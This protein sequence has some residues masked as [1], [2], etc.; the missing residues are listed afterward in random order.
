MKTKNVIVLVLFLSISLMACGHEHKWIDATCTSPKTCEE[1]GETEGEPL[2][3][4]T[5]FGEC[6]QCGQLIGKDIM[7]E[8]EN[9]MDSAA[10]QYNL[11]FTTI[12]TSVDYNPTSF[13]EMVNKNSDGFKSY[14]SEVKEV[15][16]MC[17]NYSDLSEFKSLLQEVVKYL[18]TQIGSD[19]DG[20]INHYIDNMEEVAKIIYSYQMEEIDICKKFGISARYFY[21]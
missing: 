9:K 19:S 18:P 1:C 12:M 15:I 16:D 4:T 7:V 21:E 3:H 2:G 6:E 8:I 5:E 11:S 13:V 14:I 17:K 10:K 20:A